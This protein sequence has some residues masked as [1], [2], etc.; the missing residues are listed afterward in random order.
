[1]C[2]CV[3]VLLHDKTKC[4]PSRNMK[5]EFVVVYENNSDKFDAEYCL[6][7]VKVTV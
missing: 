2:V 1:M 4:N 5:V 3:S 6:V 7:K